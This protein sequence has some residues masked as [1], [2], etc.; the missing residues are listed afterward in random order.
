MRVRGTPMAAAVALAMGAA[1]VGLRPARAAFTVH[2]VDSARFTVS[3]DKPVFILV[4]GNDGRPGDS[5]T[6]GDALHLVAVNPGQGKGTILNIPRDTYVAIPGLGRDKINAAHAAGGPALQAKAV[7]ALVGVDVP[8]V[9]DTDFAGFMGM[10]DE[11]GGVDVDVPMAMNDRFSGA[12][13]PQGR[14]HMDGFA[15][16]AFARNR[17]ID[18][19]DLRRT[20]HQGLLLLA[21][22][23]KLRSENPSAATVLRHVSVFARHGRFDGLS[24]GDLYRLGRLAASLDPQGIRSVVLPGAGG[25]AGAASVVFVD[26]SAEGLFADLRDD[27]VLQAH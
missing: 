16:L 14:V 17:Q 2:K 27:G 5:I 4:M 20:E 22:L 11:M 24:L 8:F 9:V 13:F 23:A 15:A 19:G 21:G 25:F 18:G 12:F 10:V 6:R 7:G 3:P 26:P 1:L